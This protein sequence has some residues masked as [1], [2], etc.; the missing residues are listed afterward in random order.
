MSKHEQP[1]SPRDR[2]SYISF[3]GLEYSSNIEEAFFD[4]IQ[5]GVVYYLM[6]FAFYL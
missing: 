6:L 1:Q 5:R 4:I 2:G 3:S